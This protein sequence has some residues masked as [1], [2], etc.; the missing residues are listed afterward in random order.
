MACPPRHGR[1]ECV[2]RDRPGPVGR[3]CRRCVV[4][5]CPGLLLEAAAD[6]HNVT[7]PVQDRDLRGGEPG[8]EPPQPEVQLGPESSASVQVLGG[9]DHQQCGEVDQRIE[10][11]V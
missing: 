6:P 8:L 11:P 4:G 10:R 1:P 2:E 5:H 3:P 9:I 7:N